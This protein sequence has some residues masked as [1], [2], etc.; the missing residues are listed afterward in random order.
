MFFCLTQWKPIHFL[1]STSVLAILGMGLL[2][3]SNSI[4]AAQIAIFIVGLGAGNLFPLIFSIAI[5]KM[6]DRANEISGLLIMAIVGGAVIPPI[7][8]ILS[9]NFSILWALYLLILCFVYVLLLA[10][11]NRHIL[12]N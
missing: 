6:P 11:K 1:I 5:N 3:Q 8:G 7:M 4:L 2:L 12:K 10:L 9:S